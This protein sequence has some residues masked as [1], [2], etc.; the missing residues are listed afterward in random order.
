MGVPQ[1]VDLNL[2]NFNLSAPVEAGGRWGGSV[3]ATDGTSKIGTNFWSQLDGQ[4]FS[5]DDRS[6][7]KELF[8]PNLSDRRTEGDRFTPPP[9]SV[10]YLQK[11]RQ[12][13]KA[14]QVV[15][16]QRKEHFCS[17]KF[18]TDQP[19]PLFP[20]AWSSSI[21]IISEQKAVAARARPELITEANSL[22]DKLKVATP[23]FDRTAEDGT[24]FAVYR[25][26]SLEVRTTKAYDG[27]EEIGMVFSLVS[28]QQ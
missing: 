16:Q 24:R 19:G 15:R 12:L 21:E 23:I 18:I 8:N 4:M 13:V 20:S 6:L 11:L 25:I 28:A 5:S 27:E 17:E 10:S 7:L 1:G 2:D 3:Q 26:G 14:E 9:S 22:K